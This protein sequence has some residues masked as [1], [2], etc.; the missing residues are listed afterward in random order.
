MA[1]EKTESMCNGCRVA[2]AHGGGKKCVNYA[3]AV[4]VKRLA[5]SEY[6]SE[7]H[8]WAAAKDTLQCKILSTGALVDITDPRVFNPETVTWPEYMLIVTGSDQRFSVL[9]KGDDLAHAQSAVLRQKEQLRAV[10]AYRLVGPTKIP[11]Q[12]EDLPILATCTLTRAPSSHYYV[13]GETKPILCAE[14]VEQQLGK[15]PL[16]V[17]LR[18]HSYR[19]IPQHKGAGEIW[20]RRS[21]LAAGEV[22]LRV[23]WSPNPDTTPWQSTFPRFA[24]WAVDNGLVGGPEVGYRYLASLEA[25]EGGSQEDDQPVSQA[26]AAGANL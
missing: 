17:R 2:A 24:H 16:R 5:I 23:S 4:V 12:L 3:E 15:C 20:L 8:H 22:H 1:A 18:I 19:C 26:P 7:K 25:L 13:P 10:R 6:T 9:A 11:T 14:I 21:I